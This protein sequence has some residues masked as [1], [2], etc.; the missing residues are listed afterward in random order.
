MSPLKIMGA[1]LPTGEG[2]GSIVPKPI[3]F[4]PGL[5]V[6][7]P[8]VA[9]EVTAVATFLASRPGVG[10]TLSA[11]ATPADAKG[12]REQAL[13]QKL[14]PRK[15]VIG[16]LRS[17]GARG[18]IV[19]ALEAR[20]RGED[21]KLDDDD[22]KALDEYLADVPQPT[23]EELK[24]LEQARVALVEKM[25]EEEHGVGPGQIARAEPSDEAT[26]EG[27]PAVRIDL[28]AAGQ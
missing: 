7:D 9:D 18:R 26:A 12:L 1:V 10:V 3:G 21:G 16:T 17:V 11:P 20:S 19:D 6:P 5:A 13:L 15:G 27:D 8:K 2:A 24:A 23:A 22:T 14:G 25:L 28:G 4:H